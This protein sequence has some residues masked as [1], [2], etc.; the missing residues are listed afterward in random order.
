MGCTISCSDPSRRDFC[1]LQNVHSSSRVHLPAIE[2]MGGEVGWALKL[3]I[4][5]HLVLRLKMGRVFLLSA[6]YLHKM[7]RVNF[8]RYVFLVSFLSSQSSVLI[9]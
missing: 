8:R 9:L 6:I 5:S 1:L 4:T 2:C 3:T 7:H